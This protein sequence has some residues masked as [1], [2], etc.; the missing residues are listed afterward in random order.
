ME[1]KS[2]KVEKKGEN[3]LEKVKKKKIEIFE[4]LSLQPTRQTYNEFEKKKKK[5]CAM[6]YKYN[7]NRLKTFKD[8]L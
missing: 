3:A 2:V 8:R 7:H 1:R 5:I 6:Q 4:I